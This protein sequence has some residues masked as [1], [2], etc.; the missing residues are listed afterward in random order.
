MRMHGP[1]EGSVKVNKVY[2]EKL[3][4][5]VH[6]SH[7]EKIRSLIK[8]CPECGEFHTNPKF[9]TQSC[10]AS[11]NNKLRTHS[12]ETRKKISQSVKSHYEKFPRAIKI[13]YLNCDNCNELYIDS[14][15]REHSQL[16]N[17][18]SPE[19]AKAI[20][21]QGFKETLKVKYQGVYLHSSWEVAYA[22][23]L[24]EK[25]IKWERPKN[26]FSY[27]YDEKERLDYPDFYLP[28]KNQ[29]IEVKGY[30]TEK[31]EVK[32]ED[33]QQDLKVLRKQDLLEMGI[34]Q[35]K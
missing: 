23:Y 11:Y 24:D 2:I 7:E 6:P 17:T 26:G 12:E 4:R 31:D 21:A 9:C 32:W 19:C 28:E 29:Y 10:S 35:S 22:K 34:I 30:K 14:Y 8:E 15:S 20:N 25:N 5:W 16:R 33:F 18:C 3:D 27:E 1:S 13:Y